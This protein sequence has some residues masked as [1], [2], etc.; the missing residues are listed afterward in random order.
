[1]LSSTPPCD[2]KRITQLHCKWIFFFL[3][4]LGLVTGFT[5]V[6]IFTLLYVVPTISARVLVKTDCYVD[7]IHLYHTHYNHLSNV[8]CV[9]VHKATWDK[10]PPTLEVQLIGEM[11][12]QTDILHD[13]NKTVTNTLK[14]EPNTSCTLV[15]VS[16]LQHGIAKR[17]NVFRFAGDVGKHA[18]VRPK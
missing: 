4:V 13:K 18:Q 16:Y 9:A 3:S 8:T 11:T 15:T 6:L 5:L 10:D 2:Q 1:M 14:L 12:N 17:G 7:S